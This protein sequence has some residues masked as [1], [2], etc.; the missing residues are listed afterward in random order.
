MKEGTRSVL[1]GC[2]N[3]FFHGL[4]VLAAWR[5]TYRSWP[6]WWQII[7]IFIHDIG[8]WGRQYL[9]DDTAKKGHWER[10]AH[11]AVWLFNFG[12]LRFANL[13]GQPFLFIAG[14]CPEESG[15][16]RSE[17]WLPDKRSYL[18]A[19]M[20]WLWWN[21]YVEWHGKGIGVTPPPQWRKLV[22]ENLEQKNPMGNH[23]LYIKHRGVA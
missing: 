5:I 20:I 18:V 9:S 13:G 16:P 2:H 22:A 8:V 6:K 19:P 15:Y 7:C 1:F 3:P 14:H 10:G 11:F 21:Y 23:E 12:P 4:C 17:L